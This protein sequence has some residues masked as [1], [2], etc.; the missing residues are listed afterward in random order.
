MNIHII[1]GWED[2]GDEASYQKLKT[3]F[4]KKNYTVSVKKIDWKKPLSC[5]IF[6]VSKDDIIFG[7][8]LGAILG[9]MI[10]PNHTFKHI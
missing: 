7:F 6:E 10:S 2:S 5:Q 9:R 8:S 4:K 1:P 3:L